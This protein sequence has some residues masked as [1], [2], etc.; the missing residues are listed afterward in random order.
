MF[1]DRESDRKVQLIRLVQRLDSN[2]QCNL[3][4]KHPDGLILPLIFR[5]HPEWRIASIFIKGEQG[6]V[7]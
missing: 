1:R 5:Y 4:R 3:T 6:G 7:I 2:K